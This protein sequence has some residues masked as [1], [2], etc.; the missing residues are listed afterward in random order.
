VTT[1]AFAVLVLLANY[2]PLPHVDND[3]LARAHARFSLGTVGLTPFLAAYAYVQLAALLIGRLRRWRQDPRGRLR[4]ERASNVV[5]VVLAGIQ[6]YAAASALQEFVVAPGFVSLAVQTSTLAGGACLL[7]ILAHWATSRGFVNGYVL[8][9]ALST[10]VD[11]ADRDS[12]RRAAMLGGIR[13]VLLLALVMA[14]P[15]IATILVLAGRDGATMETLLARTPYKG[16]RS[17]APRPGFPAPVSS[18][19]PIALASAL[20]VEPSTLAAVN[21]PGMAALQQTLQRSDVAWEVIWLALVVVGGLALAH[22]INRRDEVL[23][24]LRNLGNVDDDAKGID[25][26]LQR[27][28]APTLAYL[29]ALALA[30]SAA[31]SV[32]RGAPPMVNVAL[33]TAVAIDFCVAVT[34]HWRTR[35]LVCVRRVGD[36]YAVGAFR[37]ALRAEGIDAEARGTALFTLLQPFAAY[38]PAEIHVRIVDVERATSLFEHWEAG[39]PAPARPPEPVR[40]AEPPARSSVPR[41]ALI[42]GL[43]AVAL[44]VKLFPQAAARPGG[45]RGEIAIV[46]I[47]DAVDPL[48]EANRYDVPETAALYRETVPLGEGR[49]GQITYARVVLQSGETLSAA[50]D[51]ILPWL[52]GFPPPSGRRWTYEPVFEPSDEPD[53]EGEPQFHGPVALRTLVLAGD[54]V[55]TTADVERANVE[56]DDGVQGRPHLLVRLTPEAGERFHRMTE[57]WLGRRLAIVV[58][59]HVDSAPVIRTPISGGLLSVNAGVG[60]REQQLAEM[61]A[62]ADSLRP[63]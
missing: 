2:V 36:A 46:R 17:A 30:A 11:F 4:L 53:D 9:W 13:D 21:V 40:V 47:D 18:V 29:L 55:I 60:S 37:A 10:A 58:N 7:A 41:T 24:L 33:L 3:L 59:G 39:G 28:L 52:S 43:G 48:R 8:G 22:L 23:R 15:I 61:R 44:L 1:V 5:A 38:A 16:G 31:G 50:W 25:A 34:I 20:L 27:A 51:R 14:V 63:R 19:Q 32:S 54:P 45:A 62:L 49:T 57:E 42:A 56:L 12:F 35:D 26:A 6:A